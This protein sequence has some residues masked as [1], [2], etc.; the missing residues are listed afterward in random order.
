MDTWS[1][2][3]QYALSFD[4]QASPVASIRGEVD[5]QASLLPT[6]WGVGW[7]PGNQRTV[8]AYRDGDLPEGTPLAGFLERL[9]GVRSSIF[10]GHVRSF[11]PRS[12]EHDAQPFVKAYAGR[13][14]VFS[15]AGDIGPDRVGDLRFEDE[16]EFAPVGTTPCE[17]AFSWLLASLRSRGAKTIEAFGWDA[18]RELLGQVNAFG[19][20]SFVLSDGIDLIAYRDASERVPMHWSRL[21]P[22]HDVKRLEGRGFS[23]D[24]DSPI[25]ESRTL[26][27]FAT[28]PLMGAAW[29]P[30]EPGE[31]RVVR[32]GTSVWSSHPISV[33]EHVFSIMASSSGSGASSSLQLQQAGTLQQSQ[34]GSMPPPL[35]L[36]GEPERATLSVLHRTTYRYQTPVERSLHRFN[37]KPVR[38]D[39]QE[40]LEHTLEISVDGVRRE[41]EDV[42]GN[43]TT[44]LEV[45]RPFQEMTLTARS[46]VTVEAVLPSRIESPLRRDQIP[47][48]WMPWQRQMM[49][50]YLM[51]PELPESALL[52]LSEFAMSFVE[53][54]DYDLVQTLLDLNRT[55]YRDFTY[56][57][58]STHI[59]TTPFEVYAQRRGVCQDF[60]NV[61][62]CVA[63]LLGVPARYRVG[64]IHTGAS[65]EN[66]IQSEA[67]HAWAE[68]YLP[69]TGWVGF[70][71]TNGCLAG[72]DHVRIA[73]GRHF[74]DAAP[75]SGTIYRGGSFETLEVEVR[76]ERLGGDPSVVR[77]EV[78]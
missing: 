9:G 42:F 20:A 17:H 73:C 3:E 66:Q 60:A 52:E 30:M 24:Y 69:W 47:L 78:P 59:E 76:V 51:P 71:P 13:Q 19:P 44:L 26:Y 54:S 68:V 37:L 31:L 18:M 62:I 56:L 25:D 10:V 4:G 74:R 45:T 16:F 36:A 12:G 55:I 22:P 48:V 38:D 61:F 75:T 64:Y 53:R 63:R 46:K 67:S 1:T 77:G 6:H 7:Y 58:G 50:A 5:G 57:P 41:F 8:T 21:I 33:S 40:L 23:L 28:L 15:C 70:D 39:A 29:T 27:A 43:R 49:E 35:P 65:Y 34:A 2:S 72:S 32:R 14:W 11:Q